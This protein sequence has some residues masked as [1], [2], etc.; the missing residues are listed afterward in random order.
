M[1]WRVFLRSHNIEKKEIFKKKTEKGEFYFY[2]KLAKKIKTIDLL[3]EN[4]PQI[5]E[6][7]S[8]KKSMKWGD[9]DL[10]WARPLKSILAIFDN[11]TLKFNY[12]HLKSCNSTY[13]DKEF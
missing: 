1:L 2:K 6:K 12:H 4:I 9:F 3:E 10:N 8:W 13:L 7:I 5:L 11:K